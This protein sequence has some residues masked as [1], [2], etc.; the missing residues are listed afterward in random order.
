LGTGDLFFSYWTECS[1]ASHPS[2]KTA[3]VFKNPENAGM[4]RKIS[5]Q[6][7]SYFFN[8][9]DMFRNSGSGLSRILSVL[10][11]YRPELGFINKMKS[12]IKI[13]LFEKSTF[14][15]DFINKT[16]KYIFSPVV[17]SIM[18]AHRWA[19]LTQNLTN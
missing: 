3:C 14:Q 11:C 2:R 9:H 5:F 12:W 8:L 15:I 10:N 13:Y 1:S 4:V 19:S 6:A 16:A 7:K 18:H 17:K